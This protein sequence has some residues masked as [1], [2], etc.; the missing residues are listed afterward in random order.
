MRTQKLI[1]LMERL[2][3]AL[4]HMVTSPQNY[5][6]VA[7]IIGLLLTVLAVAVAVR[8]CAKACHRR[9]CRRARRRPPLHEQDGLVCPDGPD[10]SDDG[11][12]GVSGT[13]EMTRVA[14]VA[15]VTD[16][17]DVAA[18]ARVDDV[19]VELQSPPP[20][21]SSEG[22]YST[23]E[24]EDD[25]DSHHSLVEPVDVES[26]RSAS[27]WRYRLV[28]RIFDSRSRQLVNIRTCD[29]YDFH[30]FLGSNAHKWET[31]L[32]GVYCMC[33][34][35][36][37][38]VTVESELQLGD[39]IPIEDIS[40]AALA[41]LGH[42]CFLRLHTGE[43]LPGFL[44]IKRDPSKARGLKYD[45]IMKAS[46]DEL[47][48]RVTLSNAQLKRLGVEE[49]GHHPIGAYGLAHNLSS[50]TATTAW[51]ATAAATAAVP[52]MQ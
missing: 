2:G 52:T 14:D 28:S 25:D 16:V 27:A 45:F 11:V 42:K 50:P 40:P 18:E 22:S 43:R 20:P 21:S 24:F 34:G 39:L 10:G 32:K 48:Q 31:N 8:D 17:T 1:A 41:C 5:A 47:S 38:L 35:D 15:D 13:V 46:E 30:P 36:A 7:G 3:D 29:V 23:D 49:D 9:C 44:V 4:L 6:D 33:S 51:T 26:I 19:N 12:G 37:Q